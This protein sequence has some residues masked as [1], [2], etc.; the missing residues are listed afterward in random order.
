MR[1]DADTTVIGVHQVP[2]HSTKIAE[3]GEARGDRETIYFAS[4]LDKIVAVKNLRNG[5]TPV[6]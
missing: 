6:S 4:E 2:D 3:N 5:L 1:L